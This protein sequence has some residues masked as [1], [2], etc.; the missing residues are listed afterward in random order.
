M[1][2]EFLRRKYFVAFSALVYVAL[3]LNLKNKEGMDYG[4]HTFHQVFI[5]FTC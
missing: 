5:Q 1:P 2:I 4:I 3:Y